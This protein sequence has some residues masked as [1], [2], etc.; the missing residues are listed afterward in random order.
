MSSDNLPSNVSNEE[1]TRIMQQVLRAE[2]EKLH[3]S[4]PQGINN[5]IEKILTEEVN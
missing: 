2:K 3:M 5:E 4:V 1:V